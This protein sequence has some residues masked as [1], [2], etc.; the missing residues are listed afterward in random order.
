MLLCIFILASAVLQ[1]QIIDTQFHGGL[2]EE[3]IEGIIAEELTTI[4]FL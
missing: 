3:I 2:L 4:F 1:A